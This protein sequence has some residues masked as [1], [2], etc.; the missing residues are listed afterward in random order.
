MSIDHVFQS[1]E[2]CIGPYY[3]KRLKLFQDLIGTRIIDAL[4]YMPISTIEKFEVNELSNNII[5]KHIITSINVLSIEY[6]NYSKTKPIVI[7]GNVGDN[8]LELLFF[9]YKPVYLKG[10]F[11]V[12]KTT[13]IT[14]KL[15]MSSTNTYQIINPQKATPKTTPGIYSIYPLRTGITME[16]IY[17]IIKTALNILR[18]INIPEWLPE[19]IINKYQFY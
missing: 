13:K 17:S 9:N 19:Y 4:L 3:K 5:N 11:E 8:Q 10:N 6:S 14:G 2:H 1:I 12:G 16:S 18:N 7:L 15:T